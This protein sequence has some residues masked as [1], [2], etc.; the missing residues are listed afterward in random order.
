L[1]ERPAS[2]NMNLNKVVLIGR[3]T[4]DP[5]MRSTSSGQNVTTLKMATNRVWNDKT[6]QRQESTEYHIIV[7]WARLG[8]ISNQYL[9]KGSLVMI[10]GRLQ[11]RS[12]T[13]QNNNKKYMTEII[14]EN[15]QMGPRAMGGQSGGQSSNNYRPSVA[16]HASSPPNPQQDRESAKMRGSSPSSVEDKDIPIIDED[17]PTAQGVDEEEVSIKEKDLPF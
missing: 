3:L 8:E 1:A 10:E 13:D 15:L 6:G 11:T 12:W 14:A 5:E 2:D 16:S 9:N 4:H 17:E 7:A